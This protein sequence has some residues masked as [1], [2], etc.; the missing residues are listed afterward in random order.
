MHLGTRPW[1]RIPRWSSAGFG[2]ERP[3]VSKIDLL[4]LAPDDKT[5]L[6]P[7]AVAIRDRTL[8]RI[9]SHERTKECMLLRIQLLCVHHSNLKPQDPSDVPISWAILDNLVVHVPHHAGQIR[10][11]YA[12]HAVVHVALS[13]VHVKSL[14]RTL[15]GPRGRGAEGS[16]R[17][18][19]GG[20][21]GSCVKGPPTHCRGQEHNA[22][23]EQTD[24][25]QLVE[26]RGPAMLRA[27]AIVSGRERL[28]GHPGA[29]D[30]GNCA[31]VVIGGKWAPRSHSNV[32]GTHFDGIWWTPCARAEVFAQTQ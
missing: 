10:H 15:R 17:H 12:L 18:K 8:C 4:F 29:G 6:V 31:L 25:K 32:R 19:G 2:K 27:N 9:E 3:I 13:S 23:P 28:V 16:G 14:Q 1:Q 11:V 22:N 20:G 5:I 24:T 21:G 30:I 26:A 7:Q